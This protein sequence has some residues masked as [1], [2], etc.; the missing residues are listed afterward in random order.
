M[1]ETTTNVRVRYAETDQ[2]GVVYHG[3]FAQYFEVG[4]AE[5]IRKLGYT[6]KDMELSGLLMPVVDLQMKF[7]R[8]ATYDELLTIKTT[9]RELP[10]GHKIV[11]HHEILNEKGEIACIGNITLYFL[12][13]KTKQKTTPPTN[14]LNILNVFFN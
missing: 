6:Y 9:I 2:M 13:A 14:L 10:T 7:I 3:N 12:D 1:F 11:F 4:R 8:P 5:S